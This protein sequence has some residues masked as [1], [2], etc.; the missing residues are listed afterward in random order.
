M[1]FES[2]S[3]HGICRFCMERKSILRVTNC[4]HLFC[5]MCLRKTIMAKLED[6]RREHRGM[7]GLP[8]YNDYIRH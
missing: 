2:W 6:K 4:G 1:A 5:D 3:E 8:G 7:S